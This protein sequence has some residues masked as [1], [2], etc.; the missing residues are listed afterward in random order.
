MKRNRLRFTA[1]SIALAVLS[2]SACGKAGSEEAPD[3]AV[4]EGEPEDTT[5]QTPAPTPEEEEPVA[6][7]TPEPEPVKTYVEEHGIEFCNNTAVETRG[8]AMNEDDLSDYIYTDVSFQLDGITVEDAD[9]EGYKT[10]TVEHSAR[11]YSWTDGREHKLYVRLPAVM[12]VDTYTGLILP[13]ESGN[14][15]RVTEEYS[16]DIEWSGKTY[17]ISYQEET[18]WDHGTIW[19]Q[20]EDGNFICRCGNHGTLM[21]TVPKDY[22]GLA[23]LLPPILVE[24]KPGE[25]DEY[26]LDYWADEDCFLFKIDISENVADNAFKAAM[27]EDGTDK[28]EV[29]TPVPK[30]ED[31]KPQEAK[32][33]ETK[34]VHTHSY[35]ESVTANPTCSSN[36]TKTFTCSCGDS[37]TESIPATGQHTWEAQ[38]E[39]IHHESTGHM[40][41]TP[42]EKYRFH[43]RH[44]DG[45]FYDLDSFI[46]HG[47]DGNYYYTV[48]TT[49]EDVWVVDSEAW[50][51]TVTYNVC[52]VCGATQ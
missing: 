10:V 47:G 2:L 33:E 7:E 24:N 19:E 41:S 39:T 36:G 8:L 12:A 48:E 17:H 26:I 13:Y 3:L 29:A 52:T 34:P 11:G 37:Y 9:T 21:I 32:Q 4:Q 6:E 38:T 5:A 35:S 43:C 40:E 25:S 31:A 49:Y 28:A 22:G 45:D 50:D 44:C 18:E 14:G 46:A 15:D 1:F 42:V 23:L 20:A 51:E 16:S 27:D 30:Q